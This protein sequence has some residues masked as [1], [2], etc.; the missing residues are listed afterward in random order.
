LQ[1]AIIRQAHAVRATGVYEGDGPEFQTARRPLDDDYL[2]SDTIITWRRSTRQQVNVIKRGL[3]GFHGAYPQTGERVLCLQNA[4]AYG[5]FNGGCYTTL[6]PFDPETGTMVVEVDGQ[7]LIIPNC[8]F[9][10]KDDPSEDDTKTT[11]FSFGYALTCHKAQGSE[12]DNV[13]VIDELPTDRRRWMYTALTRAA[14][15]V[16]VVQQP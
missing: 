7:E 12:F 13:M 2:C 9:T 11:T 6:A 16:L 4:P 8:E 3:L 15:A 10:T 14:Q 5:V 1:S